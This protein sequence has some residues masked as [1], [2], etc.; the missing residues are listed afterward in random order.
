MVQLKIGDIILYGDVKQGTG[1]HVG[2]IKSITGKALRIQPMTGGRIHLV[3][4]SAVVGY[5]PKGSR[6]RSLAS[7][8]KVD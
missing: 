1:G 6:K 5:W 4:E 2:R 7:M 8:K 3:G